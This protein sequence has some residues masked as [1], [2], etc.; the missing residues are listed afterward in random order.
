MENVVIVGKILEAH[1]E[2][3]E[4]KFDSYVNLLIQ[5]LHE[6]RDTRAENI[7]RSKKNG[8]YKVQNKVIL[9]SIENCYMTK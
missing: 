7:I 3:D 1:Y 4:Q 8:T 6:N 2:N 5:R 9:D